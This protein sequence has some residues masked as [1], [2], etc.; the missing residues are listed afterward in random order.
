MRRKTL[1]IFFLAHVILQ[2]RAQ[3][4]VRYRVIF[5]GDAGEIN[6]EQQAVIN[7]ASHIIIPNKTTAVFLG[8]N[9][10]PRGMG[11]P[12]SKE[13]AITKNILQSQYLPLRNNGAPVYFV[14]GNHD[15]DK[16]GP[17][18]LQK[19]KQQ[20]TYL[21]E[22]ND[23]LLKLV[24]ANG[25]PDPVEINVADNLTIIAF[26]SEWWLFPFSKDNPGAEC[27]C[28][29]KKDVV[30][31]MEELLYKNR[32]KIILLAS[33][34]PFQ[35]YGYHGGYF[36]WKDHLFPFTAI[37]KN[38]FIPL[39]VLGSLYPILRRAFINPEDLHHPLYKDMKKNINEVFSGFPNLI[40]VAGHEHGLE[41]IKDNQLQ[42]ISGA[43]AKDAFVKKGKNLLF[44][45]MAS[46]FVT[47]DLL[48]NNDLRLTYYVYAD[49]GVH[50]AFIYSQPY[51][52]VKM[53]EDNSFASIAA[54]SVSASVHA[55]F[56]KVSKLHRIFFGENYRKEWAAQ[57]KLPVIKISEIKGGLTPIKRGGGHQTHS[58]RLE[59]KDGKE[60][61]LRSI[62]KYP[63]VLLPEQLRET[64]AKNIVIDAMSAQHPYSAL[65]VTP[66][67][68]ATKVPHANPIVGMVVPDKQL[69]IYSK[70]FANTICLLEERDP[71]G[72][73]DNTAK[74][75]KELQQDNDNNFDST[76]FLR[77]RLL[78]IYLGD[79]DRHADQWRFVDEKKGKG[80][81]YIA[82]PRDRD[83]VLY[84]NQGFFPSIASNFVAR[85]LEGFN[86]KIR[87]AGTFFFSS[88]DLNERLLNQFSYDQWMQI[89][90]EFVAAI[91][92]S[93]LETALRQLPASL[94]PIR[95][96][97]LFQKLKSRRD[98][99]PRAM[100]AYYHF[101]NKIADIQLTD[102]NEFVEIK[103]APDHGM[104]ISIY[105]ISK[106]GEIKDQLFS[107]IYYPNITKEI[108]LFIAKGD[109]SLVI[110]DHAA[111]KLRIV[112]GDGKK[113]YNLIESQKKVFVYDKENSATFTGDA[114]RIK[115]YLSN[116]SQNTAIIPSNLFNPA[117]P[118]LTAGYN[119]D[120]G[121]LLGLGIKYTRQG[122]RKKPYGSVQQFTISHSFS[123]KAFRI[124][125]SGEWIKTIG[126][127]DFTL[128][129]DAFA[130][131][132]T[133]NFF[134]TGNE[135]S[136]MKIGSYKKY[137]RARFNLYNV[138]PALRW[139]NKK[140]TF[141]SIGP[142]IQFYSFDKDGNKGRFIE[143]TSFIHSYDS[144]TLTSDKSHAGIVIN[145]I[146]DKRNNKL[147]PAWGSYLNIR[148]EGYEG[149]N[150]YSKAFS[151]II[152]E[153]AL[154]KSI[155]MKSSVV[156]ANRIGGAVSF[157]NPAFY[158]SVFLGGEGNLL[159]YRQFR[160]A[161]Q[162]ML[163]NNLELRVKLADFDN[164]ILPGQFGCIGF[165]D[166]G[167]VWEKNDHSN[168][169]HNGVGGGFYFAPAQMAVI[170]AAAGYTSEGWY[171]FVALGFRF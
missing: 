34:H 136:F 96:D 58:L 65:I 7:Y 57:S 84:I 165:Y 168:Q 143:N 33:H 53:Q 15:W 153:V 146:D 109:D 75:L 155:D 131:D 10:Y 106:K 94:Y 92:D 23:S 71:L 59:D 141:I 11:L 128:H 76:A 13:E 54:D 118:L 111:I 126:S 132:N 35:S 38:L 69:G 93:V 30:D 66:I 21:E 1:L 9:I 39:P 37:D 108:R 127:A 50:A 164:Y 162:H 8:D 139:G 14:P 125:Y 151:Q 124:K 62:E 72:K 100:A 17:Q 63:Y 44:G 56:D 55:G 28:K 25:C 163:Y 18:G 43:G 145:F 113:K 129:A 49:S 26:D 104:R 161:G 70:T 22:Q 19:I 45:K 95:H 88:T 48:A 156:L 149:L 52:N 46:G 87:N 158:Q 120:D 31:R 142:A 83:Q 36:S 115:K 157:G 42:V 122:F 47:A 138:E 169:W 134:G 51:T 61:V 67:A 27:S 4:S 89:T 74:M 117:L 140:G 77:A 123:T 114:S 159:G 99:L 97:V 147:L 90:H 79:W 85:F 101:L 16:M 110:N 152:S 116:N 150:K 154:Y 29:T 82:V 107:K 148:I 73:S 5:I 135:T 102:K 137:Y 112:G 171:P 133:Q 78:D 130:P 2:L 105:K 167:R 60:W 86:N 121:L 98:D 160:F 6:K 24:P 12:G 119:I 81:H 144:A 41:L 40:H 68:E 3:D 166:I 32:Y 64:F 20:S 91:T 80:K 103:D 170:R